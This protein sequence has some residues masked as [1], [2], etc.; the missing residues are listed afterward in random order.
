MTDRRDFLKLGLAGGTASLVAACGWDGGD[1]VRPQLLAVSR[2]NDW[3]GEKIFFSPTR[4][5]RQYDPAERTAQLPSYFISR[6]TP[7]LKDPAAWRLRVDGLVRQP[8]DLSLADLT[9]LPRT[10]YT[11]KHHCVEGWTAIATW[12]GVALSAVAGR[13][14]PLPAAR[15]IRF[16]SF[17]ADYSNGWDLAS[18]MHPQTILAYGLNDNPLPAAHGAPLRLY[19]PT[20]L[21]YKMTKYLVSMTFMDKRPGGYWEDQGYPWFAGL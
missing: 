2:V 16:A 7:M 1:A 15:Y 5:A 19:S 14:E 12:H 4:L 3:V 21:G 6:T 11:V 9:A 10:T 13:C 8:L 18:A 17:D 20:K